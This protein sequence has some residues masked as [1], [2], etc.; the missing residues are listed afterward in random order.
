MDSVHNTLKGAALLLEATGEP[1]QPSL[2]TFFI[3]F[4]IV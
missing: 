1:L 3:N 2:V 4:C